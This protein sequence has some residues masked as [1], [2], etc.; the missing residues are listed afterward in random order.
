MTKSWH[1]SYQIRISCLANTS[2]LENR[3]TMNT[4][5]MCCMT[6]VGTRFSLCLIL[7]SVTILL[8]VNGFVCAVIEKQLPKIEIRFHSCDSYSQAIIMPGFH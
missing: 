5:E 1:I 3:I 2:L 6:S 8:E 7:Y 4:L